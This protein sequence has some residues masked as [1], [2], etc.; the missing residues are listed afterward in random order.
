MQHFVK[1]TDKTED[2]RRT[3]FFDDQPSHAVDENELQN[4]L[5]QALAEHWHFEEYAGRTLGEKLF[6]LFNGSGGKLSAA[7]K[8]A[9]D[10]GETLRLHFDL[11]LAFDALPIEL[12][13]SGGFL[14]LDEKK[15]HFA[16]SK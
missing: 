6:A 2:G 9:R 16:P 1:L 8:Q 7:L 12:L 14:L 11:P 15:S 5:E 10:L 4:A 13:F 3:V